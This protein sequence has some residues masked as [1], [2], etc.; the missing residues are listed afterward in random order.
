ME[1]ISCFFVAARD[2]RIGAYGFI[3]KGQF[4]TGFTD[5]FETKRWSGHSG[6]DP[7]HV[8]EPQVRSQRNVYLEDEKALIRHLDIR[9]AG[10]TESNVYDR[11]Q[12]KI[13]AEA[14]VFVVSEGKTLRV[15]T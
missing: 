5:H 2:L 8:S 13:Q 12:Q 7:G 14:T 10:V 15:L 11:R 1:N 3:N 6:N 4:Y 9:T